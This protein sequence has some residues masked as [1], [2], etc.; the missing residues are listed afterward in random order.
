MI[1]E[2]REQPEAIARLFDA[3]FE[4]VW[5]MAER[6][7]RNPPRFIFIAARGT[8]DHV[9]L[10]GKYLFETVN[11]LPVGLAAPSIATI[12]KAKVNVAGGLIIGISQS[13]E[14][15]DVGAVLDLAVESGADSLAVTNV[16]DSPLARKARHVIELHSRPE[17]A[18]AATKTYTA[19]LGALLLLSAAISNDRT[20]RQWLARVPKLIAE[21]LSREAEICAQVERFRYL[22]DCVVLGRGFNLCTAM[23][24]GLKLRET[25]N[26]RA[27][28]FAAP[29]FMHGPIAI[30]EA[31]YP[32]IAIANE[33]K[34]LDSVLDVISQVRALGA[35]AVVIGN[36]AKAL[37][38][39][40]VPFPVNRGMRVPEMISPFSSIV[41]GQILACRLSILKGRDPDHPRGL[42]KVTITR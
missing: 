16:G 23:E 38:M 19:S 7:R 2:I 5:N 14:A 34:T 29:D 11:G 36:A 21:A 28:P 20:L 15:A 25:C 27:Q 33:G 40:D 31:G 10:Y 37:K 22:E 18:V 30:V 42:Q 4:R 35:E 1:S 32:V 13:G 8:S 41:A 39:A 24:L 3:E 6:W 26:I 17:L 12:Y 9:A